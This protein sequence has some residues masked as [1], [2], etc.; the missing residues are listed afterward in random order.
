MRVQVPAMPSR[1]IALA[2]LRL[3]CVAVD[4]ARAAEARPVIVQQLQQE[5]ESKSEPRELVLSRDG[6]YLLAVWPKS[7]LRWD[8]TTGKPAATTDFQTEQA[9]LK[10]RAR[11]VLFKN[12]GAFG[13][14]FSNAGSVKD[15]KGLVATIDPTTGK[16]KTAPF[17]YMN[18]AR[19]SRADISPSGA[20]MAIAADV[21]YVV[22]AA[23]GA[24]LHKLQLS[25]VLGLAFSLDSKLLAGMAKDGTITVWDVA[26]G[27]IK[28]TLAGEPPVDPRNRVEL[29]WFD[30]GT[31]ISPQCFTKRGIDRWDI[32]TQK[33]TQLSWTG[34]APM[35]MPT[36]KGKKPPP[37]PPPL[38]GWSGKDPEHAV[39]AFSPDA[40][41][42]VFAVEGGPA[43]PGADGVRLKVVDLT[44]GKVVGVIPSDPDRFFSAQFTSDSSAVLLA[45]EFGYY[46]LYR[47]V[48]IN[49]LEAMAKAG[50]PLPDVD[51]VLAENP[52]IASWH[53]YK[54]GDRVEHQV[55]LTANGKTVTGTVSHRRS[56]TLANGSGL[57][58]STGIARE[59]SNV[60]GPTDAPLSYTRRVPDRVDAGTPHATLDFTLLYFEGK[61]TPQSKET[62]T[63]GGKS[64]DCEVFKFD[65][66]RYSTDGYG[67]A[68]TGRYWTCPDVP[69]LVVKSTVAVKTRSDLRIEVL[70]SEIKREEVKKKR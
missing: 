66:T 38:A 15:P 27:K 37:P 13:K 30:D 39:I 69:G 5:K 9:Q 28:A 14:V 2:V 7:A 22:N 45:S 4:P 63:I 16:V 42:A 1:L 8:L 46:N 59:L 47:L 35:P 70:L 61:I 43:P 26:S 60:G 44:A 6:R 21:I 57:D 36:K 20:R 51:H 19:F 55:T 12:A 67:S 53:N 29:V 31:L 48:P 17:E 62:L 58:L 25:D 64:Y 24:T 40:R 32:A 52:E 34:V 65:G 54:D 41:R 3:C 23:T 56:R 11:E 18:L 10:N 50:T 68:A 33:A 49:Q